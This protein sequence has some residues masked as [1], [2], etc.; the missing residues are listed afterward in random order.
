MTGKRHWTDDGERGS[1][2]I[3]TS[4]YSVEYHSNMMD[5]IPNII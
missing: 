4:A 3:P 1:S 2:I 5:I